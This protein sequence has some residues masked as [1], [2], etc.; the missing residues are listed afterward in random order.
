M[1]AQ[2][3][4][5]VCCCEPIEGKKYYWWKIGPLHKQCCFPEDSDQS[6]ERAV[7]MKTVTYFLCFVVMIIAVG[8]AALIDRPYKHYPIVPV[9]GQVVYWQ[10]Y[11]KQWKSGVVTEEFIFHQANRE[12]DKFPDHMVVIDG[13]IMR[14]GDWVYRKEQLEKTR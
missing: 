11:D 4:R 10:D 2:N 7:D 12:D 13:K 3:D 14:N 9:K 8:C 5:C 6:G 1:S